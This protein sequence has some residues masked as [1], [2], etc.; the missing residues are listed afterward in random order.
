MD[1]QHIEPVKTKSFALKYGLFLGLIS[2]A[3]GIM[4]FTMDLHYQSS[5]PNT[6]VSIVII[7][8]MICI[9]IY[10]FKKENGTYL[11]LGEALKI[12]MGVALIAGIISAIYTAIMLNVLDPDFMDKSFEFRKASIMEQN[13]NITE[14]QLEQN[15]ELQKNFA[16]LTYPFILIFNLFIGFVVSLIAGLIMK[17]SK[18][19]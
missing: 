8:I 11:T 17:K 18:N 1:D 13:P 16:W 3:F 6:I 15:R 10:Q 2:V 7:I 12:G 5:L 19:D 9:A 14:E 4:L